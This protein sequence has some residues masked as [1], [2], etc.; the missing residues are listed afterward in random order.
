MAQRQ[1]SARPR[2][3]RPFDEPAVL[4]LAAH[5]QHGPLVGVAEVVPAQAERLGDAQAGPAQP[6]HRQ[7][8]ARIELLEE[9]VDLLASERLRWCSRR[10]PTDHANPSGVGG[11]QVELVGLGE[12]RLQRREDP[13]DRGGGQ[14][15]GALLRLARLDRT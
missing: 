14:P 1:R 10:P 3:L 6:E 11:E 15:R 5:H 2:W 13:A 9:R 4:P 8:V 7:A 12:H